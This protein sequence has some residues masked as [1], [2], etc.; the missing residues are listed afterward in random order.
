MKKILF[1][2]MGGMSSSLI[3]VKFNNYLKENGYTVSFIGI[4]SEKDVELIKTS[5]TD[6]TIA[7]MHVMGI[8]NENRKRH[9]QMFDIV[10]VAPQSGYLIPKLK[11]EAL[12]VGHDPNRIIKVPGLAYGRANSEK[13]LG[14]VNQVVEE[15]IRASK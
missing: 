15:Q 8:N 14:I 2:C 5:D 11:A 4:T 12:M 6:Y 7:Y 9:G 13:L 10:L 1:V 3:A